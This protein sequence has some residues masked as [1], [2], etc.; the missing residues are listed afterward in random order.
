MSPSRRRDLTGIAS[1]RGRT[2]RHGGRGNASA[3]RTDISALGGV[4]A[5]ASQDLHMRR[6]DL[7]EKGRTEPQGLGLAKG[8]ASSGADRGVQPQFVFKQSIGARPASERPAHLS[9]AAKPGVTL[10]GRLIAENLDPRDHLGRVERSVGR[11]DVLGR[12]DLELAASQKALRGEPFFGEVSEHPFRRILVEGVDDL[13]V[14]PK[15][16]GEKSGQ[17]LPALDLG[18]VEGAR[19]IPEPEP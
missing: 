19:V 3:G 17:L 9:R 14:V 5:V 2:P 11:I 13:F 10:L 12:M 15:S 4:P 8:N 1:R 18:S 16:L 7:V 6:P